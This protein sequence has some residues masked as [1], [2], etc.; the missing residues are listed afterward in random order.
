[1]KLH[2]NQNLKENRVKEYLVHSVRVQEVEYALPLLMTVD[3]V[4]S[5]DV[6]HFDAL[7]AETFEKLLSWTPEL[8]IFGTGVTQ[9][10]PHPKLMRA[11][12]EQQIGIET[13]KSDAA[14]RTFNIL[15]DEG[16]KV[17]AALL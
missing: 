6:P 4:E 5:W 12:I 1:M 11:L 8:I 10:F 7:T 14:C 2:L 9:K 13:M 15:A 16:R 3:R 17:L